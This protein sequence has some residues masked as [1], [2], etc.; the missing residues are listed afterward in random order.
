[1]FDDRCPRKIF[2]EAVETGPFYV[3]ITDVVGSASPTLALSRGIYLDIGPVSVVFSH[4]VKSK[5]I[6]IVGNLTAVRCR[7]EILRYFTVL[8]CSNGN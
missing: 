1:M 8:L 3:A 4:G 5:L 7:D 2:D 6:V